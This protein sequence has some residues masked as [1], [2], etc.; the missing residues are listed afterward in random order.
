MGRTCRNICLRY[1][2]KPVSNRIRYVMGHKRCTF[3][4]IFLLQEDVRCVCCRSVLR[5]NP[6]NKKKRT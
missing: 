3:C 2:A 5:T 1:Q 6:K 4:G